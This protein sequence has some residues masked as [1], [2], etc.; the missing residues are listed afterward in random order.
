MS[1]KQHEFI[2][3]FDGV[4]LSKEANQ[5]IQKG[6]DHI[7][8]QELG[9]QASLNANDGDDGGYCGMYIPRKWIGRQIMQ[10]DLNKPIEAELNGA[11]L[12]FVAPA[13]PL[14]R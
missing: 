12:A 8:M 14:V 10:V 1:D 3:R 13:L 6:I 4:N 9:Q 5:R 7:L 2:I 11:R